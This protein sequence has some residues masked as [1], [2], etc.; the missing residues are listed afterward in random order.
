MKKPPKPKISEADLC[1]DFIAWAAPQGWTAYAE[2]GGFDLVLVN[3]EVQIGVQAKLRFNATL[4]RQIIP[5]DY[6]WSSIGPDYRA[7]LLPA[8]DRDVN[9]VAHF[10]GIQFFYPEWSLPHR[11]FADHKE[12]FPGID[13]DRWH[14][15]DHEKRVPLPDYIPDVAAGASGPRKLSRWKVAALRITAVLSL[16]GYVTRKDFATFGITPALWTQSG[17]LKYDRQKKQYMPG[18][19]LRFAEQHPAVY[20]QIIEDLRK[21][22]A[23]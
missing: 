13:P 14:H 10:C 22:Y 6:K 4:L 12:F 8:F 7:I 15:W 9:V 23:A 20:Q 11:R 17:W 18:N 5:E 3:A 21:D 19:E 1:R 2:T 16:R